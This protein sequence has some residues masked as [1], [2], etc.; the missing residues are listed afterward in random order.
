MAD[1]NAESEAAAL[2][3]WYTNLLDQVVKEMIRLE[4]VSDS[5]VQAAPMWM[6]PNEMLIAKVW[7]I[8]DQS[9]FI[10]TMSVDK[11]VADYIAGSLASS[12]REVAKHFSMKWQLDAER[13]LH[14]EQA[15]AADGKLDQRMK[16]Y[17]DRLIRCAETLYELAERDEAW[18]ELPPASG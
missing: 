9:D 11:F 13:L 3:S 4:A 15:K 12:P 17:S 1:S 5:A 2:K 6:L 16:D 7:N 10:W 8:S 18:E 14:S